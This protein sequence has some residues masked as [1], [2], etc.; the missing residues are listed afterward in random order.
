[1][2]VQVGV[3][4]R[5]GILSRMGL[6][7]KTK[8]SKL[9]DRYED[10]REVLDYSYEKQLELIREVRKGI[11]R[12]ATS[13]KRLEIQKRKLEA[14]MEKLDVQARRAVE[15]GKEELARVALERKIALRS[16]IS[17]LEGE[18]ATLTAEQQRLEHTHGKLA[19]KI[20]LFRA[21]KEVLKARYTAA[22]AKSEVAES[23]SGISE[24]M[25]DVGLALERAEEKTEQM[26]ARAEA[27]DELM[28]SGVLDD[29]SVHEDDIDSKLE[30]LSASA[31]LERELERLKS[32]A[33]ED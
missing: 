27:L 6:I 1:L 13:K 19:Q 23:L 2:P 30:E 29:L 33:K 8:V 31:E 14:Q 4:K 17:Q 3:V 11:A 5:M 10:S 22:E 7:V 26:S 9:L 32:E 16:Q 25:A 24:E 12:V 18:I 21:R 20:E 28:E 15:M